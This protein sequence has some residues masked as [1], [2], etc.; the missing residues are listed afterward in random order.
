QVTTQVR[1]LL[2]EVNTELSREELQ[3]RMNLS[4]RHNFK[5]LYLVPA[6]EAG[7]IE[8]TIPEKPNSRLQKYRLTEKGKAEL[9]NQK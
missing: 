2:K 8:R 4:D 1:A 7:L 3:S 6:L 9:A 5:R